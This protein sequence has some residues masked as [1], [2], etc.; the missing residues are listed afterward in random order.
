MTAAYIRSIRNPLK[1][2]YAEAFA[3]YLASGEEGPEP[4]R[5][6]LSYMGAQAVRLRLYDLNGNIA[7]PSL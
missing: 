3:R 5:G 7:Y 2:Q 6:A 1:R 4:D